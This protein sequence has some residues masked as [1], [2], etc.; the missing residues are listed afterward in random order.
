MI[1]F[2]VCALADGVALVALVLL[3]VGSDVEDRKA[4]CGIHL[5]VRP[6][7]VLSALAR[8]VFGLHMSRGGAGQR[9]DA[10]AGAGDRIPV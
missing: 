8:S 5:S 2:V 3:R 4:A 7:P 6:P 10:P 1:E 9:T